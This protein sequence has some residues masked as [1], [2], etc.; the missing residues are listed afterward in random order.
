MTSTE[1]VALGAGVIALCQAA[2]VAVT[3]YGIE[4]TAEQTASTMGV[5]TTLVALATAVWARRKVTPSG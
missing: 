4:L 2:L 5:V 1:P 3:S